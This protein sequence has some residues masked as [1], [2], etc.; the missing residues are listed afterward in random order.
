MEMHCKNLRI[1]PEVKFTSVAPTTCSLAYRSFLQ[2]KLASVWGALADHR[3]LTVWTQL[4][5]L[6]A[7][8]AI[9]SKCVCVYISAP[10]I[11]RNVRLCTYGEQ[12]QLLGWQALHFRSRFCEG[13]Y[14][15]EGRHSSLR[16]A[17]GVTS[18]Q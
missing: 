2:R 12:A 13:I 10:S 1:L 4:V 14:V 9:T 3:L 15:G 17:F 7:S 5:A 11:S 6:S 16:F 8:R 18:C